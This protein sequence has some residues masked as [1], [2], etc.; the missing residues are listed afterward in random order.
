MACAVPPPH[1][2]AGAASPCSSQPITCR[3]HFRS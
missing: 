3:R 2:G 1:H